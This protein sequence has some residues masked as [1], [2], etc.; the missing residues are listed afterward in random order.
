M[1]S[2]DVSKCLGSVQ[3][4]IGVVFFNFGLL[5]AFTDTVHKQQ[6]Q[7]HTQMTDH[8]KQKKQ[9]LYFPLQITLLLWM[10]HF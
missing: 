6:Y 9:L 5:G 7:R 10:K 1:I 4:L 8:I 2:V 3:D